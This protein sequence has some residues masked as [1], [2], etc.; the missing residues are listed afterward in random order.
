MSITLKW[1][2][3]NPSTAVIELFRSETKPIDYKTEFTTP[4]VTLPGTATEYTDNTTTPGMSY[5]FAMKVTQ[6]SNSVWTPLFSSADVL[7]RG[8]GPN[9]LMYGD[10][11]LGYFGTVPFYELPSV[12]G[13]I[14]SAAAI[15]PIYREDLHKF[16]RKNK[17]IYVM[18][19]GA[20]GAATASVNDFIKAIG[21]D[22]GIDWGE[23]AVLRPDMGKNT[24]V[25]EGGFRYY[26]RF[27]R[28]TPD[29]YVPTS[30]Y[31]TAFAILA[32]DPT[33]E[34]NE[35]IQPLMGESLGNNPIGSIAA[36]NASYSIPGAGINTCDRVSS[37]HVG[38]RLTSASATSR[39]TNYDDNWVNR[40][41]KSTSYPASSTNQL[42]IIIYELIED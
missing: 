12:I 42:T 6:G 40:F 30:D 35:L 14:N 5:Y 38:V 34:F 13:S 24:I 27:P 29:D 28:G 19:W 32:T 4:L 25:E 37:T 20:I 41:G 23:G 10:S 26:P 39:N 1:Q 33:T 2:N 9:V 7:R 8:P 15:N 36:Y 3:S 17:I 22:N 18:P 31:G 16:I 21:I 11:R